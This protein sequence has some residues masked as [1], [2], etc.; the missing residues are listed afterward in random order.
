MDI[1]F[2]GYLV[3]LKNNS[4]VSKKTQKTLYKYSI[5]SPEG[6]SR[7]AMTDEP[8]ATELLSVIG[9]RMVLLDIECDILSKDMFW[10]GN[11]DVADQYAE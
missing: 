8:I 11:V 9:G 3:A 7:D 4:F 5:L 1:T 10:L 6:K 2:R